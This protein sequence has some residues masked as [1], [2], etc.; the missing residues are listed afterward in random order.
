VDGE[1]GDDP[2]C[3]PNQL[4]AFSLEHPVLDAGRWEDVLSTCERTLVTPVGLRSLAPG[5][6]DYKAR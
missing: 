6:P 3:R 4:I 1:G 2:A 5:H